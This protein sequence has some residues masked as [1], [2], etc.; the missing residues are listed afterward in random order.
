[1]CFFFLCDL[2]NDVSGLVGSN[3]LEDSLFDFCFLKEVIPSGSPR[4][5]CP[6][7]AHIDEDIHRR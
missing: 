5:V 7:R 2:S 4:S 1:M 3:V 6:I